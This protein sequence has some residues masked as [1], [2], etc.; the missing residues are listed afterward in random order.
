MTNDSNAIIRNAQAV[1]EGIRRAAER[2]GRNPDAIR[3]V[4]ATKFV[5]VERIRTAIEAGITI[6]GE[7]RLQ[8][9]LPKIEAIGS[10]PD[11]AWHF[12]GRLQ[13]RKAK[14]IVGRFEMIHS[15]DSVDLAAE[16]DRRAGEAGLCQKVLLEVNIG[17]ESSKT[18]FAPAEMDETLKA[19]DKMRH[20]SVR[21][22]MTIPP[23]SPHPE[24]ARP[25]FRAT[26]ELAESAKRHTFQRIRLEELSMGMSQDYDIA[27]EEGATFVRVGTV[28]F[29]ARPQ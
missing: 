27:I 19:L 28:I 29:G 12:I 3:L 1:R 25:Y 26:R 22:L 20:L 21:G 5:S 9:A 17:G 24:S 4:A 2:V 18:G 10:R 14:A 15:V 6:L 7:S 16:I 13:R 8:E 23:Y 11:V